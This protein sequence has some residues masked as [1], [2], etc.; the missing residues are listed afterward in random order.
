VRVGDDGLPSVGG[1]PSGHV[2]G[3]DMDSAL[4]IGTARG[5]NLEVLRS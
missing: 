1:A 2:I 3:I 5:R 4:K